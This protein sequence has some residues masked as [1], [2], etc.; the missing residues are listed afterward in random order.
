MASVAIKLDR[1]VALQLIG[2]MNAKRPDG[3]WEPEFLSTAL[4]ALGRATASEEVED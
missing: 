2:W 1:D 4:I 3:D